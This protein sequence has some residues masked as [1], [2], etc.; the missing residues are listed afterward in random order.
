[1]TFHLSTRDIGRSIAFLADVI[2]RL[3]REIHFRQRTEAKRKPP[4]L[5]ERTE[6]L[7]MDRG[8]ARRSQ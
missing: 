8:A 1:M 2:D 3:R 7:R 4:C 5:A 6:A